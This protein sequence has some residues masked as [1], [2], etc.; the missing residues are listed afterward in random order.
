MTRHKSLGLGKIHIPYNWSYADETERE[1]ADGFVSADIGKLALQEDDNSLWMLTA[2]T[3]TWSQVGGSQSGGTLY[4]TGT[5]VD[6]KNTTTET[7]VLTY[8]VPG[9][10]L[11]T[12]GALRVTIQARIVHTIAGTLTI[13]FKYGATTLL[14]ITVPEGVAVADKSSDIGFLLTANGAT[15]AQRVSGR[16][17]MQDA[18]NSVRSRWNQ[19][20]TATEDS[21]AAKTLAVTVQWGAA[22][23]SL[24]YDQSWAGIETVG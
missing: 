5:R 13:R 23:N 12:D 9:G 6:V 22:S 15:N 20:G 10:T 8:S 11:G 4:S 1:A 17:D 2:I 14:T 19:E 21:T 18:A 24:E 16:V 3:P 7:T